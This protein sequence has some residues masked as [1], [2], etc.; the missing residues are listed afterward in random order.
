MTRLV[1]KIILLLLPMLA[2]GQQFT[3]NHNLMVYGGQTNHGLILL[4]N[5]GGIYRIQSHPDLGFTIYDLRNDLYMAFTNGLLT[6]NGITTADGSRGF[7]NDVV[8]FWGYGAGL[9]GLN[10]SQLATGTLPGT[11]LG[12]PTSPS[13]RGPFV[14]TNGSGTTVLSYD[15][16]SLTNLQRSY[17]V[18]AVTNYIGLT[19]VY[20]SSDGTTLVEIGSTG[21]WSETPLNGVYFP[22]GCD[23]GLGYRT[24]I[25]RFRLHATNSTTILVGTCEI[26]QGGPNSVA[27]KSTYNVWGQGTPVNGTA[28][29]VYGSVTNYHSATAQTNSTMT[30]RF[31]YNTPPATNYMY[32]LG[33]QTE[34]YP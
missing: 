21:L 8:G 17:L 19:S 3:L 1:S 30:V 9:Y 14:T 10:A 32:F 16:G 4:T 33:I 26:G 31:I 24:N 5:S 7:T 18:G 13:V 11:R 29:I 28:S 34:W 20:A 12:A 23:N 15:G 2:Y 22:M 6:V 27:S 25:I